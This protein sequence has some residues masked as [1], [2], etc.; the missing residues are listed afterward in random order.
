MA[1]L[2]WAT[3]ANRGGRRGAEGEVGA[4]RRPSVPSS[5]GCLLRLR[6]PQSSRLEPQLEVCVRGAPSP[7]AGLVTAL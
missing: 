7:S 3:G 4:R 1:A 6:L 2:P 5:P